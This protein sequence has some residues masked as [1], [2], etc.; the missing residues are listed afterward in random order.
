MTDRLGAPRDAMLAIAEELS[1]ELA[2][3]PDV[4]DVTQ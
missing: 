4:P 1:Q 2:Q 3:P